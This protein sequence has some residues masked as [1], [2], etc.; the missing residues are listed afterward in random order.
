MTWPFLLG[1]FPEREPTARRD[2]YDM[3]RAVVYVL[4]MPKGTVLLLRETSRP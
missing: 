1:R 3:A 2:P 4:S